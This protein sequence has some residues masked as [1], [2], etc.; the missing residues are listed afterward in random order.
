M[1][2]NHIMIDLETLSTRMDAAI[3]SI[4][5]VRFGPDG[6]TQDAFY[7]AITIDS[8][9]AAGRHISGGTLAWWM[10]Q[11]EEARAVFTDPAAVSMATALVDLRI[12]LGEGAIVWG[13]GANFDISILE[14]AYAGFGYVTPWKYGNVRCMRT[15]RRIAGADEVP[16]PENSC[17]HNA[18]ADAVWQAE[19][20]VRAWRAGVGVMA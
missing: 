15:I 5:A 18:L 16:K 3:L 13:N 9:T 20:M 8:N 4:G 1:N 7:R 19:W 14:S 6:V 10:G 17:A 2:T 11:S 12:W